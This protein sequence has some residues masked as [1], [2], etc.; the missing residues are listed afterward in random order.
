MYSE[1]EN[2][3]H[4]NWL[5]SLSSLCSLCSRPCGV[6]QGTQSDSC[7]PGGLPR[8]PPHNGAPFMSF[9]PAGLSCTNK[10]LYKISPRT[11]NSGPIFEKLSPS[12]VP[13]SGSLSQP[14]M[15]SKNWIKSIITNVCPIIGWAFQMSR[16][17]PSAACLWAHTPEH[18]QRRGQQTDRVELAGSKQFLLRHEAGKE[19]NELEG[20]LW[21][22]PF[23]SI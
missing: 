19:E 17:R 15:L 6:D 11:V 1:V 9:H 7:I 22:R 16:L 2:R 10:R 12:Y 8:T 18:A 4:R 3:E 13:T 23:L 21:D 5:F 20:F 14:K